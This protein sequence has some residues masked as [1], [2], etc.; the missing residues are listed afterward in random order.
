MKLSIVLASGATADI[1]YVQTPTVYWPMIECGLGVVSACLPLLRPLFSSG[2][3]SKGFGQ[4][5]D[6]Q[7][8][9]LNSTPANLPD[10]KPWA[11]TSSSA[12]T[13]RNDSE[14]SISK[15]VPS[16]LE[17]WGERASRKAQVSENYV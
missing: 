4:V 15:I 8:V 14:V 17:P 12:S 11:E 16:A 6:I 9:R 3:N 1:S 2:S 13:T 5:R 10:L 7:S